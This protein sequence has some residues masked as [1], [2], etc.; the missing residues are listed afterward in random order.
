MLEDKLLVWKLRRG[1]VDALRRIYEKY[2]DD[3]LSIATSLL[4]EVG[5]GEDIVHDVF[6]AF[7]ERADRFYLYG[8]LRRYLITCMVHRIHDTFRSRMYEVTEIERV[9]PMRTDLQ[10]PAK[11][12]ADKET[13]DFLSEGLARLPFQQCEVIVLHLQG[14]MKFREI[15]DLQGVS[16]NTVQS[17]YRYGLDKLRSVLSRELME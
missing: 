10:G 11:T 8:S 12:V 3:L 7:A 2:K 17:R 16:I 13:A 6:V 9:Q 4:H 15:A 5:T 1:D 14:D